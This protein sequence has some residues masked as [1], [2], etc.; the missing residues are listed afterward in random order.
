[1]EFPNAVALPQTPFL[2][3]TFAELLLGSNF[4][5]FSSCLASEGA[6]LATFSWRDVCITSMSGWQSLFMSNNIQKCRVIN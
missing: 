3:H 2:P 5:R 4:I 1:M 6:M